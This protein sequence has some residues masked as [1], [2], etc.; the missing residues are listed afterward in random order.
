MNGMEMMIPHLIKGL[1]LDPEKIKEVL[2]DAT[3]KVKEF[4]A[5]LDH[6][7]ASLQR[8]EMKFNTLPD[9][10]LAKILASKTPEQIAKELE[11]VYGRNGNGNDHD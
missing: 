2:T 4:D 10:E 7:A 3:G 11:E 8:L 6:I 5:K 9:E 1:G